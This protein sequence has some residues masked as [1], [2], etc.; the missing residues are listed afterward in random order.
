MSMNDAMR[1]VERCR[2]DQQFR[3]GAYEAAAPQEFR[4]WVRAGGF[5]FT[6]DEIEDA[7]R[8]M[9]TRARDEEEALE[10]DELRAWFFL[11]AGGSECSSGCSA[12]P[13][14]AGCRQCDA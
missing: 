11:M 1:F 4:Q 12:C 14:S 10:I 13:S 5:A 2:L 3:S 9:K 6:D 7:F 8:G